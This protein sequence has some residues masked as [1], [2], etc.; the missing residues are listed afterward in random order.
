M[1][2]LLFKCV[3][4]VSFLLLLTTCIVG[5]RSYFVYDYF[6]RLWTTSRD[7]VST[8][9]QINV[10]LEAGRFEIRWKG[11]SETAPSDLPFLVRTPSPGLMYHESISRGERRHT[12]DF[13][14]VAPDWWQGSIW[15]SLGFRYE[16]TEKSSETSARVTMRPK[17]D[18]TLI[19]I[20][21][22]T[23]SHAVGFPIWFFPLLFAVL[24]FWVLVARIRRKARRV[25]HCA[26][27]GY[28]LRAHQRG[29]KCPECGTPISPGDVSSSPGP[30]V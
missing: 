9:R 8:Q 22:V 30:C 27:C 16:V 1:R 28:D 17:Y 19:H 21:I 24:P 15:R 18:D 23:I 7:F 5:V 3:T 4:A 12:F 10:S 14:T 29:Q 26:K 25:G 13:V 6:S 20:P 11:A 2:R